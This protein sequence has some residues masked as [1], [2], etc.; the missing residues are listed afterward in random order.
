[1]SLDGLNPNSL[2][3]SE[4][5]ANRHWIHCVRSHHMRWISCWLQGTLVHSI[6]IRNGPI[7]VY[8]IHTQIKLY[9]LYG[10]KQQVNK[11]I[12]FNQQLCLT[13]SND[14]SVQVWN[15]YKKSSIL[16]MNHHK[17]AVMDIT[18]LGRWLV[19]VGLD[20]S[21]YIVDPLSGHIF[22]HFTTRHPIHSVHTLTHDTILLGT[23]N[24]MV[25]AVP[26]HHGQKAHDITVCKSAIAA[27]QINSI[28]K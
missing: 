8:N 27:Y 14:S 19:S 17:E 9:V 13:A 12:P 11:M 7:W 3:G 26:I 24:G 22:K 20:C 1:M 5:N 25:K 4:S 21:A 15:P 18:L 6:Q 10:H 16:T 28:T 23:N 2:L